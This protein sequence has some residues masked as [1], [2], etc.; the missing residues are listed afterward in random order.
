MTE[1]FSLAPA[2]AAGM[3]LGAFF[4]GG[5][6]WTVRK[7]L[8]SRHAALW[9]VGSMLLRAAVVMLGLYWVMG[10]SWQ[11]LLAALLG[12]VCARLLVTRITKVAQEAD[13]AS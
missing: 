5:L 6:W 4:F 8:A 10:D 1:T 2:L 3:L 11:R 12:F 13:H 9:F 7:G